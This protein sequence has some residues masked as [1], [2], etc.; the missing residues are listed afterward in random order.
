MFPIV[1]GTSK[2]AQVPDHL[3]GAPSRPRRGRALSALE[4]RLGL[5]PKQAEQIDQPE[6]GGSDQVRTKHGCGAEEA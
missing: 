1:D 4:D 2:P 3:S 6:D 5:R